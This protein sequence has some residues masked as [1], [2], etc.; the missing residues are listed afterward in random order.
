MPHR[1]SLLPGR[2]ATPLTDH[3]VRRVALTF[4]G[5]D[6]RVNAKYDESAI[7]AFRVSLDEDGNQYGEVV[8]GPDILP[9]RNVADPNSALSVDAA[10]AHELTHYYRWRDGLQI[11]SAE[12]DRLRDLD[13]ALT[14]LQAILRYEPH[15][16]AHDIRQLI[17]DA[18]QRLQRHLASVMPTE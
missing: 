17:G 18:I 14:S 7:T 4:V 15:L 8:F 10:V 5:M 1:N 12:L 2:N 9:G 11:P 16:Q 13:E 3:E 6:D